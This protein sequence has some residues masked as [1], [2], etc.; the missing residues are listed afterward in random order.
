MP[1][2]LRLI[3]DRSL[4][5]ITRGKGRNG[6]SR[7]S[8]GLRVAPKPRSALRS[9]QPAEVPPPP[10]PPP[11]P[12]ADWRR[13]QHQQHLP[14]RGGRQDRLEAAA[15]GHLSSL[16]A[17]PRTFTASS[18]VPARHRLGPHLVP[19]PKG[20]EA[21][22]ARKTTSGPDRVREAGASTPGSRGSIPAPEALRSPR[23]SRQ[24]AAYLVPR[25]KRV[26]VQDGPAG[27]GGRR[28]RGALHA[29]LPEP[30]Q[31]LRLLRGAGRLLPLHELAGRGRR[32]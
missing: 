7:S 14:A 23:P 32:R 27:L 6:S 3:S 30:E 31:P 28:R 2:V 24:D 15:S 21:P 8:S 4:V 12:A 1:N 18:R 17:R 22:A 16:L 5:L 9:C 10:P 20:V 11:L 29:A 13:P 25:E 26:F 19:L